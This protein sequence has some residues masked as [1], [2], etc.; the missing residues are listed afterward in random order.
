MKSVYKGH[1]IHNCEKYISREIIFL[2]KEKCVYVYILLTY[3]F[4]E[5]SRAMPNFLK[6][7][8]IYLHWSPYYIYNIH[9]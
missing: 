9:M 5:H 4:S 2:I 7:Y 3:Y 1:F 8:Y 6:Q